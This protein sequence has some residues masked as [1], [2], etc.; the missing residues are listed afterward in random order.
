MSQPVL[1]AAASP[2]FPASS[3]CAGEAWV[4]AGF[5]S[6][7]EGATGGEPRWAG[8]SFPWCVIPVGSFWGGGEEG[9]EAC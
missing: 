7:A 1:S 4:L 6:Q 3:E 5:S 8:P 2:G 9:Q